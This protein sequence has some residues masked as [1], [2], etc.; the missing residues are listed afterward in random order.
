MTDDE[1]N[2]VTN[3]ARVRSMQ[4]SMMFLNSHEENEKKCHQEVHKKLG[5]WI[6][7]LEKK[8]GRGPG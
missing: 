7:I 6:K 2:D 3:L 1:Y 8:T 4:L 5:Q